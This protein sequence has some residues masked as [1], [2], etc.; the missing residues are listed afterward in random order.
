[1]A[2]VE[3]NR[4]NPLF[5]IQITTCRDMDWSEEKGLFALTQAK[6]E[7]AFRRAGLEKLESQR[8]GFFPP[9]LLNRSTWIQ[10]IE[11]GLEGMRALRPLLPFL[12][13]TAGAPEQRA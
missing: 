1:M 10:S 9:Q 5:A 4:A 12:L 6:V 7:S 8:F 11:G 2:F 3:P 13:L